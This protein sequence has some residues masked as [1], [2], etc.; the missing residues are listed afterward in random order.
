MR[1]TVHVPTLVQWLKDL[2]SI[3]EPTNFQL[4][5]AWQIAQTLH[6]CRH[7]ADQEHLDAIRRQ[8]VRYLS[9][10]ENPWN[11]RYQDPHTHIVVPSTR[12]LRSWTEIDLTPELSWSMQMAGRTIPNRLVK[13]LRVALGKQHNNIKAILH[14]NLDL[15]D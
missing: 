6:G 9:T 1:D 11:K 8:I 7:P 4:I 5:E 13:L 15:S 3:R 14:D 2:S 12:K 10:T